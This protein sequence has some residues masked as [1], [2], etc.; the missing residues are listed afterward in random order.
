M[1]QDVLTKV[2]Y[3][4]ASRMKALKDFGIITIR[5]LY[6]AP[7]DEL[8]KIPNIGKYYAKLIKS[9]VNDLYEKKPGGL[10]S[11]TVVPEGKETPDIKEDLGNQIKILTEGLKQTVEALGSKEKKRHPKLYMGLKKR[12]GRL[13]KHLEELNKVQG[14]LPGEISKKIIKKADTLNAVLKKAGRG[15]KKKEYEKISQRM[16]SFSKFLKKK[17]F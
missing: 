8:A 13:M 2:K 12:T 4:G 11:K 9:C 6:E 17:G 15:F 10:K 3:I 7:T 16:Q 5:Q 1:K 14:N